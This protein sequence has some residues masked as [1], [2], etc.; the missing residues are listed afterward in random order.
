MLAYADDIVIFSETWEDG[1]QMIKSLEE[2]LQTWALKLNVAKSEWSCT[3][4][5]LDM[6]STSVAFPWH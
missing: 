4:T 6:Y 1:Q 3:T 5:C 2:R